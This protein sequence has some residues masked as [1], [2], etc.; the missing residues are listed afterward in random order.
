[1]CDVRLRVVAA[2]PV[3]PPKPCGDHVTSRLEAKQPLHLMPHG[4]AQIDAEREQGQHD[5]PEAHV[6]RAS[7]ASAPLPGLAPRALAAVLAT[8][9]ARVVDGDVGRRLPRGLRHSRKS[10]STTGDVQPFSAGPAIVPAGAD[11]H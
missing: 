7:L 5:Q 1:V 6:G 4:D 2:G 9:D 11:E 3:A 8:D 10:S